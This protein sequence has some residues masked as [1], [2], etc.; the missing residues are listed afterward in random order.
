LSTG[1]SDHLL[2][3]ATGDPR[4]DRETRDR[5]IETKELLEVHADPEVLRVVRKKESGATPVYICIYYSPL[6]MVTRRDKNG[7]ERRVGKTHAF[8]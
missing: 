8:R 6:S 2:V 4:F 3:E 7:Q 5:V 1:Y